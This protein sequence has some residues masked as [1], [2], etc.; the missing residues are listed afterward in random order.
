[1]NKWNTTK[2]GTKTSSST[3]INSKEKKRVVSPAGTGTVVVA[4]SII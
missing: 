4:A 1:M 3:D 2:N